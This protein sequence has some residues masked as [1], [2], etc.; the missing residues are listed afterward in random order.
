MTDATIDTAA[1]AEI[2]SPYEKVLIALL[3]GFTPIIL[4]YV[5]RDPSQEISLINFTYLWTGLALSLV[6]FIALYMTSEKSRMKLFAMAV[7]APA[8]FSNMTSQT[9]TAEAQPV[10]QASAAQPASTNSANPI[11][12]ISNYI[13]DSNKELPKYYRVIVF[14]SMDRQNAERL[15]TNINARHPELNAR[16]RDRKGTNEFFGVYVGDIQLYQDAK[17]FGRKVNGLI[18]DDANGSKGFGL[19][20]GNFVQQFDLEECLRVKHS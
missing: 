7:S 16:V 15:A 20:A 10:Q 2:K 1:P 3:A 14:S 19:N 18:V 11:T 4:K 9:T 12:A 17:A 6:G 8:V 5:S 13:G